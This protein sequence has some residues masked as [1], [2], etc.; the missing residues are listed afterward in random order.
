M[1]TGKDLVAAFRALQTEIR[2][3]IPQEVARS[4]YDETMENF[5]NEE[6]GN[7]GRSE[8]WADRRDRS[9]RNI[10]NRLS[11]PKLD[12]SG[13]LKAGITYHSNSKSATLRSSAPYS[14]QHQTG[15]GGNS[16]DFPYRGPAFSNPPLI[17][18]TRPQKR[19]FM[20]VGERTYRNVGLIYERAIKKHF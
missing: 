1:A 9:G 10:E 16:S 5:K 4:M 19:P 12:Y 14:S 20:G 18:A 11:Y 15:Q 3:T 8:R 13:R 7:D 6:Y 17:L 2:T